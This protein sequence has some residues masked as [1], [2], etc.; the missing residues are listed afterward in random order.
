MITV[1]QTPDLDS[2]LP[3]ATDNIIL[4]NSD[5]GAEFYFKL[6][7]KV[8]DVLFSEKSVAKDAAGDLS[9]N[10][11]GFYDDYFL[12]PDFVAPGFSLYPDLKVKI[13]VTIKELSVLD[14]SLNLIEALPTFYIIKAIE[15]TSLKP[16]KLHFLSLATSEILSPLTGV[17]NVPLNVA[18]D[19]VTARVKDS[20]GNIIFQET[21]TFPVHTI[22][23][24]SLDLSA[25]VI[26]A[27]TP[28][29]EI[30]LIP[31]G[32]P[33]E[34]IF[35]NVVIIRDNIY[36][37]TLIQ[38]RNNNGILLQRYIIGQLE[39]DRDLTPKSY[40]QADK[41]VITYEIAEAISISLDSGYF[42]PNTKAEILAI[43]KSLE[44]L[45][46]ASGAS[47]LT[48]KRYA[49]QTKKIRYQADNQYLYK[50]VLKLSQELN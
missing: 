9:F 1:N 31:L 34:S 13:D 26:P 50:T 15:N 33:E 32:T 41:T 43:G 44:V 4:A 47:G 38:Y 20:D 29:I 45:M 30:E 6:E 23:A 28:Y 12:L 27:F 5:A 2:T 16:S 48:L 36:P 35:F 40:T 39:E 42:H 10:F 24:Y 21:L 14:D 19:D 46:D 37:P 49:S 18:P 11:K 17:I 25:L 7:I 8:N 3:D 22:A